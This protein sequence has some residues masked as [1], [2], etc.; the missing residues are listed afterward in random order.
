MLKFAPLLL[1]ALTGFAD[2]Q[3]LSAVVASPYHLAE[4]VETH[5]N[6]DWKNVWRA[7]K[8]TD[9]S[10]FLPACDEDPNGPSSCSTEIVTVVDPRQLILILEHRSSSF[11][12]FLRYQS[13]GQDK[14]QFSG[15]YAP[16]VKYF[17]PE[18]RITRLGPKPF[19]VIT[20]Q[21]AAGTGVSSKVESWIDLTKPGLEP[22]LD[23][24]SEADYQ[25]FAE[26]IARHTSGVASITSVPVER[27]TVAFH[28]E[29][30][31]VEGD[32][33][34]RVG[35][36]TDR[37]VYTRAKSG[38]FELDEPLSTATS[39]QIDEFYQDFDSNDFDNRDFL[40]FN[41]KGLMAIANGRDSKLRLWL[42]KFLAACPDTPESR[43]L[44]Q[45]MASSR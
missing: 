11:Q 40:E 8:I 41:F 3:N 37:V 21:G 18:H 32:N 27:I 25:P 4:F 16:F 17:R 1:L 31:G 22:V 39:K 29:F 5:S 42:Q 33:L 30:D 10:I 34:L 7:L 9:Q 14:W 44:G 6:F 28:I 45:A 13:K 15:A 24:T 35:E 2:A 36:R 12:V 43:R 20:A 26:G 19:L 23:F 38:Q